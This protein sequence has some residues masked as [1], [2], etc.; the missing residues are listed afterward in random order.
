[1]GHAPIVNGLSWAPA[2]P[3]NTHPAAPAKATAIPRSFL[4]SFPSPLFYFDAF[5]GTRQSYTD[6]ISP[7]RSAAIDCDICTSHEGAFIGSKEQDSARY[8]LGFADTT[9]H[10]FVHH[11]SEE[12]RHLQKIPCLCRFDQTR[13]DGIGANVVLSAFH[14]QLTCHG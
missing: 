11:R 8:F 13:R 6:L 2:D 3:A 1:M 5:C 9:E 4:I 7:S 12:L 10:Q 14:R